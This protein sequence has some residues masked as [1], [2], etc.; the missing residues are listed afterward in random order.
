M[1][2]I[3]TRAAARAP[4]PPPGAAPPPGAR[5]G[6]PRGAPALRKLRARSVRA[7]TRERDGVNSDPSGLR[8][9]MREAA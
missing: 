2:K 3:K 8:A 5:A 6:G 9:R 4:P 7:G 1:P